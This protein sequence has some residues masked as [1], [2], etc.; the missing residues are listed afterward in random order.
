MVLPE[1][2]LADGMAKTLKQARD[3]FARRME[4]V[5]EAR[6]GISGVSAREGKPHPDALPDQDVAIWFMV[7][8]IVP[9][10]EAPFQ[11]DGFVAEWRISVVLR[12]TGGDAYEFKEDRGFDVFGGVIRVFTEAMADVSLDSSADDVK[13]VGAQQDIGRPAGGDRDYAEWVIMLRVT[14]PFLVHDR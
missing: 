6:L 2:V 11:A 14:H 12:K 10:E 9:D 8:S 3:A 13:F 5:G 7:T 4:N 1:G